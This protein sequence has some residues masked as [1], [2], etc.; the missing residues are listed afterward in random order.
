MAILR[1]AMEVAAGL[2]VVVMIMAEV[3]Q[4]VVRIVALV[5]GAIR[6]QMVLQPS[7]RCSSLL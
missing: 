4:L 1:V 2:V 3:V 7:F 6:A 5:E